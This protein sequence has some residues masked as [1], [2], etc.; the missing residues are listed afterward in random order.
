MANGPE[1]EA[2]M[3]RWG[4]E[5]SAVS[6]VLRYLRAAGLVPKSTGGRKGRGSAHF[7]STHMV[8][9]GLGLA[10]SLATEAPDVAR[11]LFDLI[12]GDTTITSGDPTASAAEFVREVEVN[13]HPA[14]TRMSLGQFLER[15]I[16]G[17]SRQTAEERAELEQRWVKEERWV[18]TLYPDRLGQTVISGWPGGG[19]DKFQQ[20]FFNPKKAINALA[21]MMDEHDRRIGV[22]RSFNLP[23]SFLFVAAELVADTNAQLDPDDLF[24]S[25]GPSGSGPDSNGDGTP[26]EAK[27]EKENPENGNGADATS[28]KVASTPLHNGIRP[29]RANGTNKTDKAENRERVRNTQSR[30]DAIRADTGSSPSTGRRRRHEDPTHARAIA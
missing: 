10:A 26:A 4:L 14:E 23:F 7:T 12:E 1:V 9:L 8:F 16:A 3:I 6:G 27:P 24:P 18:F 15:M 25:S 22:A 29:T 2:A 20:T 21:V 11:K 5:P 30:F 19:G 13:P 17:L 28:G